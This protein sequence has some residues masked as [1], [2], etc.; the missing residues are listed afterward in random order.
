M[1]GINYQNFRNRGNDMSGEG[2]SSPQIKY[3]QMNN[4]L[5]KNNREISSFW[6][7]KALSSYLVRVN[8]SHDDRYLIT[9]NFRMDG[10][11]QFAPK[12]SG[13]IFHLL[14]PLGE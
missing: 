8:Y 1:G 7:E 5:E 6:N 9:A 12:T 4:I 10:A 3:Y 13:V 14:Q 2:F 11:T